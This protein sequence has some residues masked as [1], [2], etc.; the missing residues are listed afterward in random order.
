MLFQLFPAGPPQY[1]LPAFSSRP[2]SVRY[3][4]SFQQVH[5][6]TFFQLFPVGPPQ[7]V[8]PALSSRP[9]LLRSSSSFQQANL[10]TFFQFFPA[11][12][13]QYVLPALSSMPTPV[14]YSSSFQQVHLSTFFQ[15][16]PAG[17]PQYFLPALSSRPTSVRSSCSLCHLK[18]EVDT[19]P[20][21][22]YFWIRDDGQCPNFYSRLSS[23]SESFKGISVP[24]YNHSSG[25][26]LTQ[27]IYFTLKAPSPE[28]ATVDTFPWP[29]DLQAAVN[30]S[31]RQ[32]IQ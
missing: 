13:P 16:F 4:S 7:Y 31:H 8:I 32:K 29:P 10:I 27:D 9:T 18:T 23:R 26:S 17:P 22:L 5:L 2:T 11:G 21:T 20:E 30:S 12:L 25:A 3:S 14:R 24:S 28:T 1:V 6:S 19:V 15:L